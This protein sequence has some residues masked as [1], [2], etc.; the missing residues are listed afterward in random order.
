MEEQTGPL[1]KIQI[2]SNAKGSE[3]A[4]RLNTDMMDSFRATTKQG[5]KFV[6]II[7]E[8]EYL[9]DMKYDWNY[10]LK[11]WMAENYPDNHCHENVGSAGQ[12]IDG[13][14]VSSKSMTIGKY[15]NNESDNFL[16]RNEI[17]S[18]PPKLFL[19]ENNKGKN[20]G[21][22]KRRSTWSKPSLKCHYCGLMFLNGRE[23]TYH[24]GE[25]H[26]D[27]IRKGH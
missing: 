4:I 12:I 10:T 14:E 24:E 20:A 19:S 27:K 3:F 23:R 21:R 22:H 8:S 26:A 7:E 1:S 25:W 11:Y 17:T 5:E 9:N 15:P 18:L 16:Q 6:K 2:W 13:A